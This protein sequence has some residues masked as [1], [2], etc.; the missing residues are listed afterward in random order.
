MHNFGTMF[1]VNTKKRRS[2]SVYFAKR[3]LICGER[4]TKDRKEGSLG[5]EF[6]NKQ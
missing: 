1:L 3:V 4:E 2:T 5:V 6:L